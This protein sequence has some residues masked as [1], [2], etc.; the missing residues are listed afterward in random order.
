MRRISL[1]WGS[2]ILEADSPRRYELFFDSTEDSLRR[3]CY[4]RLDFNPGEWTVTLKPHEAVVCASCGREMGG[5]RPGAKV[6]PG[7]RERCD[8]GVVARLPR[9]EAMVPCKSPGSP[10]DRIVQIAAWG[11]HPKQD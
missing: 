10:R 7:R 2:V 11:R 3:R 4:L 8:H 9:E 6:L 5:L 1:P